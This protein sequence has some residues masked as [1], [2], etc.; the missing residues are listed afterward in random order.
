MIAKKAATEIRDF[1][2]CAARREFFDTFDFSPAYRRR[3]A[4]SP[5]GKRIAF[6]SNSD[7]NWEIYLMNSDGSDLTRITRNPASDIWPHWLPDGSGIVFA[8]ER[9]GKFAI[10]K[11]VF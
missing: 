7:S 6:A 5:D 3:P 11:I 2:I 8:S 10:Y 1:Q 9:S 4:V